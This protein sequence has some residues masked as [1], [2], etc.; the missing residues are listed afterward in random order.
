MDTSPKVFFNR[1]RRKHHNF[2]FVICN[3]EFYLLLDKLKFE[4]DTYE[5]EVHRKRGAPLLS[6]LGN[7]S[8]VRS[9]IHVSRLIMSLPTMHFN[10][11]AMLQMAMRITTG[12]RVNRL[13]M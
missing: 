11:S 6:V 4:V 7:Q 13:R 9:W 12:M 5:K 8:L 1:F 3:Y 10:A 2:A